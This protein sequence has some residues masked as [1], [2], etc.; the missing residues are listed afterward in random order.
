LK[1]ARCKE[2]FRKGFYDYI[3]DQEYEFNTEGA[4]INL[5][6]WGD[7]EVYNN[8]RV[9]VFTKDEFEQCFMIVSA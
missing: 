4:F 3:Q 8:R 5:H 1:L 7:Y 6:G 2:S 9:S